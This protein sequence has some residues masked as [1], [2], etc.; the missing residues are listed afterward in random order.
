MRKT[1]R[2]ADAERAELTPVVGDADVRD[3]GVWAPHVP[4]L[5]HWHLECTAASYPRLE[6][7]SVPKLLQCRGAE[8]A[9]RIG[10]RRARVSGRPQNQW[11]QIP[12]D[13]IDDFIARWERA[14]GEHSRQDEARLIAARLF[15]LYRE[16]LARPHGPLQRSV[17][18]C[19]RRGL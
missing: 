4:M 18:P 14:F 13:R 12:D 16:L 15:S 17:A 1:V 9:P 7:L 3:V 6:C 8:L 5:R 11:M 19:P 10:G 2:L